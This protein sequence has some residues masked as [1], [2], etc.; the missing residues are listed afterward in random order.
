MVFC[1]MTFRWCPGWW[2]WWWWCNE[3][4]WL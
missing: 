4:S 2:W 1:E 3:V